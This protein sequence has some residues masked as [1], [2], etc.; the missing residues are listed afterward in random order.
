M[1]NIKQFRLDVTVNDSGDFLSHIDTFRRT[2][3]NDIMR[4]KGY[5]PVLDLDVFIEVIYKEQFHYTLWA[6]GIYVGKKKAWQY[7]G[8]TQHKLIKRTPRAK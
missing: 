2:L 1:K 4:D 5:I 6:Y 8:M 7:E 3:I